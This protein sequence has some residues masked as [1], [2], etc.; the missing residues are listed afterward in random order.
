MTKQ[1]ERIFA[2]ERMMM[3]MKFGSKN[4]LAANELKGLPVAPAPTF[5]GQIENVRTGKR[6]TMNA[7]SP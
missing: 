7:I 5:A 3:A 4:A 1:G 6:K 2:L